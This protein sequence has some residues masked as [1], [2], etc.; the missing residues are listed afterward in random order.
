MSTGWGTIFM[1]YLFISRKPRIIREG[2]KRHNK[3]QKK[4]SGRFA[5]CCKRQ[6][7]PEKSSG[8]KTSNT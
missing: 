6:G 5:T 1:Q 7:S 4:K 3:S 8:Q 2:K